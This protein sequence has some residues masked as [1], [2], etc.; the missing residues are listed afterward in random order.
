MDEFELQVTALD[1]DEPAPEDAPAP[2]GPSR[3]A[4]ARRPRRV[5]GWGALIGLACALA[6]V[7]AGLPGMRDELGGLFRGPQ[8]PLPYGA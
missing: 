1:R 3:T 6:M 7:I 2:K 5:L 4:S 8:T